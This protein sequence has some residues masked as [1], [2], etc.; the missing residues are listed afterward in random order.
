MFK[1]RNTRSKGGQ[2]FLIKKLK[3]KGFKR[4]QKIHRDLIYM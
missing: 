1:K 3:I 4:K 2:I